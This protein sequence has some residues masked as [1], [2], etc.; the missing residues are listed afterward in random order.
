[1][2]SRF[3]LAMNSMDEKSIITIWIRTSSIK[4]NPFIKRSKAGRKISAASANIKIYLRRARAYVETIEKL[5]D[6]KIGWV[7]NGPEREAVIKR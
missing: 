7:A 4:S 5:V 1:M 6:V 3:A 2:R